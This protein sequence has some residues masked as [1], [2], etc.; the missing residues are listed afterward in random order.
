MDKPYT[1]LAVDDESDVLLFVKT[2]LQTDG[3]LVLTAS[4]GPTAL[5]L[6]RSETPDV[7][8]LDIMMPGM[9]GFQVLD[10]LRKQ[11]TTRAIP[12]VMLTILQERERK[13]AAIERGVEYYVTKPFEVHDLLA[14]VRI[15][16]EA[17]ESQGP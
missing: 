4:D 5:E 17:A 3:Y 9:D 16:I 15:A 8:V 7:I 11:E 12:V 2:A 6:A 13:I 10:E 14:K 1:V